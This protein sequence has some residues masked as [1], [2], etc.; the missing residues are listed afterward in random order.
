MTTTT[1]PPPG[2]TP[3][4][5]VSVVR[6]KAGYHINVSRNQVPLI[7]FGP[8]DERVDLADALMMA[9]MHVR[10]DPTSFSMR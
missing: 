4:V 10:T 1:P 6:N 7:S 3:E 5:S 8:L 9:A 2:R